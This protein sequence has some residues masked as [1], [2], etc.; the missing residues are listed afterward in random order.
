MEEKELVDIGGS[1]IPKR[2]QN[3]GLGTEK[4]SFQ[5]VAGDRQTA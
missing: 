3:L 2:K 5:T 1:K 4:I